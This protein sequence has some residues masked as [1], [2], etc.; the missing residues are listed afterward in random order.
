MNG[1]Q[2]M[3]LNGLAIRP[4]ELQYFI[5]YTRPNELGWRVVPTWSY[6]GP[7]Y[8]KGSFLNDFADERPTVLFVVCPGQS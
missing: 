6:D 1:R 4:A 2:Q 3:R 5:Y 8:V 7:E